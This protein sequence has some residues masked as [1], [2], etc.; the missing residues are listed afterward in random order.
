MEDWAGKGKNNPTKGKQGSP[1]SLPLFLVKKKTTSGSGVAHRAI[2]DARRL[3]S[4]SIH[5]QV[6]MGSVQQ[7]LSSLEKADLFT[8]L[9]IASF[10]NSIKLSETAPEGHIY[11]SVD[12]CS[13]QTHSLGSFSFLRAAQGLHQ[14][15]SLAS[16]IMDRLSRDF[17]LDVVKHFADDILIVHKEEQSIRE[18]LREK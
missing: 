17:P 5:R 6:Y 7:N 16:W 14:S 4:A 13:F 15:T 1:H 11:S 3:N 18:A 8:N 2:L 9:D 12:Y 10:F